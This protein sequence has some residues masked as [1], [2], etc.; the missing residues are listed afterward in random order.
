MSDTLSLKIGDE[1]P[2]FHAFQDAFSS[3]C[4]KNAVSTYIWDSQ[5]IATARKRGIK[6]SKEELVY[7]SIK[8]GCVKGGKSFKAK[9][10]GIRDTR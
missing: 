2:S 5:K 9:G 4:S 3:F 10:K 8:F 7:Y 1:F 6:K